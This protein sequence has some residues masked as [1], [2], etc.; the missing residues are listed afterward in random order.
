M[1]AGASGPGHLQASAASPRR[2]GRA[3]SED[4]H[5]GP[6][7][8]VRIPG[9]GFGQPTFQVPVMPQHVACPSGTWTQRGPWLRHKRAQWPSLLPLKQGPGGFLSL[10]VDGGLE[11]LRAVAKRW[12]LA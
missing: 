4:S 7:G 6:G 8:D 2:L 9:G 10:L 5:S 1:R 3:G 12:Y 11:P